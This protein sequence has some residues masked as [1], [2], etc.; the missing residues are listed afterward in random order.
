MARS[1]K[2]LG[3]QG[4]FVLASGIATLILAAV[5]TSVQM[6]RMTQAFS[7]VENDI[8][9][10]LKS[11]GTS[12]K[13]SVNGAI[14]QMGT[15]ISKQSQ[16]FST[17]ISKAKS[18]LDAEMDALQES[19]KTSLDSI[20]E[21]LLTQ[22]ESAL[23]ER[24]EKLSQ[25]FAKLAITPIQSF[26]FEVLN[27]YCQTA[28]TDEDVLLCYVTDMEGQNQTV[29]RNEEDPTLQTIVPE[30]QRES[31][32][33]IITALSA[34]DTVFDVVTEIID[35]DKNP[36]GALHLL[37]SSERV[38]NAQKKTNE[39]FDTA[40]KQMGS[41][42]SSMKENL[43]K[44]LNS[45]KK[46]LT[47]DLNSGK[48]LSQTT[49]EEMAHNT[50]NLSGN[51]E[52]DMHALS[53]SEISK[54][55]QNTIILS[56]ITIV[57]TLLTIW[58]LV[59]SIVTPISGIV[60][61]LDDGSEQVAVASDQV[62]LS[63]QQLAEGSSEQA[64]AI[65]QTSSSLEEMASMTR[66][67]A[68]N[69]NQANC[70]MKEANVVV[71]KAMGSMQQL[72]RSMDEISRASEE[73]SK[74]IKTID[75][76]AFQTN[77]LALNAAVEAA[78]AGD[79]GAGF[80]VVADEV[81]NLAMRAANAARTTAELIEGTRK[82]V[83]DGNELVST[84]SD[85]F[86]QVADSSSKIA[87]FVEEISEASSEQARGIDQVNK[88]V[89][90]MENVVQQN[91]AN[92]EQSSGASVELK[93]QA[94]QMKLLVGQLVTF[95]RGGRNSAPATPQKTVPDFDFEQEI[96]P[97]KPKVSISSNK[98]STTLAELEMKKKRVQEAIPFDDDDIMGFNN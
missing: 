14:Q 40:D 20:S 12:Q 5:L 57:L 18:K 60:E 63:S 11:I 94:E 59:R 54:G 37:A 81:R 1:S 6:W 78:R 62:S 76:I 19:T 45:M 82:Q 67:N 35:Q 7:K 49:L 68:D 92:S 41:G 9:S 15:T 72:T 79:A 93:N 96:R 39:H 89:V 65:E 50:I 31:L 83:N 64:A 10:Q 87:Q 46:E 29:F 22:G 98:P 51:L 17:G 3:I 48:S 42:F 52:K 23:K 28:C 38:L 97:P 13:Q 24:T 75:E 95:I 2:K 74:I 26:D 84:T 36:V 88:A 61:G 16:N 85:A 80:A 21:D 55:L 56:A 86:S 30:D 27:E 4:R 70:L 33:S 73:T 71:E 47:K 90:E 43:D 69:A 58:L 25:L 8:S 53:K 34:A 32:N 91:A 44:E 66:R 77:L